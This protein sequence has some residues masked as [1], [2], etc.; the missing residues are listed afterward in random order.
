MGYVPQYNPLIEGLTG[1]S[2]LNLFV[3]LR[4]IPQAK[5][6]ELVD[7]WLRIMGE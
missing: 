2:M 6:N 3:G 5:Q 1:R 7:K 4:G